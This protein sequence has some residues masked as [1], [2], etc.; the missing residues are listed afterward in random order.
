MRDVFVIGIGQT[1]IGEW[2]DRSLRQLS[3]E[4][5]KAAVE[6]AGIERPDALYVG[7]MLAGQL[8]RQA[9]LGAL[10]ADFSG[11]RGIEAASQF[12]RS[13]RR[14]LLLLIPMTGPIAPE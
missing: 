5:L 7:N 13:L 11:W 2:W 12:A 4:A 9:H 10:V 3:Y 6:D 8:S 1:P 14:A